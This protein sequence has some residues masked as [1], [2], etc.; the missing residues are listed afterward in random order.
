MLKDIKINIIEYIYS[1]SYICRH[2]QKILLNPENYFIDYE[3]YWPRN[4]FR[5]IIWS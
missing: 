3:D 1:I 4:N 2:L 5:L